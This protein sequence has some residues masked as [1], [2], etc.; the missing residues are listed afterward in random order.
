[1][2]KYT[3]DS[4]GHQKGLSLSIGWC[5]YEAC[6]IKKLPYATDK[7]TR[8]VPS[9]LCFPICNCLL[10]CVGYLEKLTIYNR[11]PKDYPDFKTISY[12]FI[13]A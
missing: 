12:N 11:F 9:T 5:L 2:Y 10:S 13:T 1:M 3:T 4:R 8:T 7:I 6:R